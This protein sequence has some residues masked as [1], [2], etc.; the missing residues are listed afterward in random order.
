M[1]VQMRTFFRFATTTL[2]ARIRQLRH[3]GRE[4]VPFAPFPHR[5]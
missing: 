4:T 5:R 2:N 1:N 3:G